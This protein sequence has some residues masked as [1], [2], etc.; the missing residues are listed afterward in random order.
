[1]KLRHH[2]AIRTQVKMKILIGQTR[3]FGGRRENV[4]TDIRNMANASTIWQ[5]SQLLLVRYVLNEC[6]CDDY[7]DF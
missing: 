7:E 5:E 2:P 6:L 3:E 1:M 4:P